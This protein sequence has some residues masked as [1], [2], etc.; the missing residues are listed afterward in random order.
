[1][2]MAPGTRLPWVQPSSAPH[3]PTQPADGYAELAADERDAL[4]DDGGDDDDHAAASANAHL[5]T[6]SMDTPFDAGHT[7][8]PF[9]S[10]GKSRAD[11]EA[12]GVVNRK[13]AALE[14]VRHYLQRIPVLT[15]LFCGWRSGDAPAHGDSLFDGDNSAGPRSFLY[16]PCRRAGGCL[17]GGNEAEDVVIACHHQCK[18]VLCAAC[19]ID[20]H[21]RC[22]VLHVREAHMGDAQPRDLRCDQFLFRKD[23]EW[24]A[25]PRHP[26]QLRTT[27]RPHVRESICTCAHASTMRPCR[28]IARSQE[29]QMSRYPA[30]RGPGHVLLPLL[31][32]GHASGG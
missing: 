19:D 30:D 4:P 12:A 6:S 21:A 3:A 16:G 7:R 8:D 1:M 18:A 5:G 13:R 31:W 26:E 15:A 29:N 23:V 20:V 2:S 14:R 9:R 11:R 24:C 22:G 25:A 27:A 10:T 28:P 32:P 17:H